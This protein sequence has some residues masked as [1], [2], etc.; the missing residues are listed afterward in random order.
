[1]ENCELK[2]LKKQPQVH[3]QRSNRMNTPKK[4]KKEKKAV[5]QKV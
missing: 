1:M 5:G 2:D 3:C 4:G